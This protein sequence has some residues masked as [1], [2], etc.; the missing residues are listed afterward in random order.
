MEKKNIHVGVGKEGLPSESSEGNQSK[1]FGSPGRG[2]EF[3]PQ[4]MENC[5]NQRGALRDGGGT[6]AGGFE[7]L[8]NTRRVA[9]VE[10]PEFAPYCGCCAHGETKRACTRRQRASHNYTVPAICHPSKSKQFMEGIRNG[11]WSESL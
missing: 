10:I 8:L 6:I 3:V 1:V 9:E 7:P 5:F 2:D 11:Y 4:S